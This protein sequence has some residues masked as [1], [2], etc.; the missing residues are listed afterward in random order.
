MNDAPAHIFISYSR[1]DGAGAA[2]A[3]RDELVAEGFAIWQ[4]LVALEGDRDWGSQIEEALRSKQLHH[5]VLVVTQGALDS[6]YVRREIRLARQEG[7]TVSAV[8]GPGLADL[9]NLPRWL[10]HIYDLDIPEQRKRF[11]RVI[12]GPASGKRVPMMA[13]EPPADFVQGTR[14][15]SHDI[16]VRFPE[17]LLRSV[18]SHKSLARHQC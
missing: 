3:L 6:K 13:P 16:F 11:I 10:G 17:W 2:A 18:G 9:N 5:L 14:G 15:S 1:T 12:G 7:K 4:D 8:R